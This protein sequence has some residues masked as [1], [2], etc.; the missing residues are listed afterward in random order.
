MI[1]EAPRGRG[2]RFFSLRL[3]S[4]NAWE[5][6]SAGNIFCTYETFIFRIK[7]HIWAI[8][9]AP[10]SSGG[11]RSQAGVCNCS[12]DIAKKSGFELL[13]PF[14]SWKFCHL[15]LSAGTLSSS[16]LLLCLWSQNWQIGWVGQSSS[17][18]TQLVANLRP[19]CD[20]HRTWGTWS[21]KTTFCFS[22]F[23]EINVYPTNGICFN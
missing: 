20:F 23:W 14:C 15:F 19:L 4:S 13:W 1:S 9:F 18:W 8:Y 3:V 12:Q 21:G 16:K 11:C 10:G 5:K 2:A 22:T 6:F 7:T 17:M